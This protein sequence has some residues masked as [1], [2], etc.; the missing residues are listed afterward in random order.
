M[1]DA[2][3]WLL[4]LAAPFA[5]WGCENVATQDF[6][7]R[8]QTA[9]LILL[10]TTGKSCKLQLTAPAD[11]DDL[12]SVKAIIGPF[13]IKWTGANPLRLEYLRLRFR[14]GGISDGTTSITYSGEDLGYIWRGDPRIPVISP[15]E[16]FQ[17]SFEGCTFEVGGIGITNKKVSAFG[18]GEMFIYAT[19][20]ADGQRVPVTSTQYFTFRFDATE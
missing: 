18:Q 6:E 9:D 2:R 1:I 13:D 12:A 8:L 19:T 7:T 16:N 14:G 3:K 15:S 4:V 5:L 11:P 10:D 20:E 17:T